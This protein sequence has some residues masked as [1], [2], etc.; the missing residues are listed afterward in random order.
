[1]T[2]RKGRVVHFTVAVAAI[3]L[4]SF[5]DSAQ[6]AFPGANGKLTF[7]HDLSIYAMNSDGSNIVQLTRRVAS[8]PAFS[9]DGKRIAFTAGSDIH[10]MNADGSGLT[11]LTNNQAENS[12]PS[13][14]PDGQRIVFASDRDGTAEIYVM[15]ADGSGLTRLTNNAAPDFSPAFSPD[16]QRIAFQSIR[17]HGANPEVYAMDADGSDEVQLTAHGLGADPSFSPDGARIAYGGL[18]GTRYEIFVMNSDG[19]GQTA[20]TDDASPVRSPSFSPDGARIAYSRQFSFIDN[21]IFVM[22][23]DGSGQGQIGPVAVVGSQPDWGTLPDA[24][25]LD[26]DD[27]RLGD[28][29]DSCPVR[30]ATTR[31]GCPIASRK[32]TFRYVKRIKAFKGRLKSSA[33]P[34]TRDQRVT[35]RKVRKGPDRKIGKSTSKAGGK[36]KLRDRRR[37]GSYYAK[38]ETVL[39]PGVA[40]C[41]KARSR[42]RRVR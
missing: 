9:P 18:A 14:S 1:M 42:T 29:L 38:V 6:A 17:I 4:I 36:Y 40:E 8:D 33:R 41:A 35:V 12:G 30:R 16:G 37:G 34:C 20:L 24:V 27:D 15:N 26:A 22:N 28:G 39:M 25:D 11:R 23:S 3:A 21:E 2:M 5:S 10:V 13:F 31:S 7:V 19:S 32:L